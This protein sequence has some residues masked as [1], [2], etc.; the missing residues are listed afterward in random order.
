MRNKFIL[1]SASILL[2][3][4]SVGANY[5]QQLNL[6]SGEEDVVLKT[7]KN[8]QNPEDKDNAQKSIICIPS[9]T[10]DGR[11]IHFVTPCMGLTFR[12]V[13]EDE[14]CY[15]TEIT[16]DVIEIP[17]NYVGTYELQILRGDYIFYANIENELSNF[18]RNKNLHNE[19]TL[20][21]IH[22]S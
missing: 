5:A 20:T 3:V 9:V 12:L 4:S 16:S 1:L 14:V 19:E 22:I 21:S 2:C 7:K 13:Q 8:K 18:A 17:Q 11:T 15:E 10:F 6:T